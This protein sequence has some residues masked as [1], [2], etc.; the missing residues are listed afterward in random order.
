MKRFWTVLL[1]TLM[2]GLTVIACN[3]QKKAQE[4]IPV[5]TEQVDSAAVA[6]DSTAVA[7]QKDTLIVE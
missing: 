1:C 2:L 4:E 7:V 6:C 5:C 3:N